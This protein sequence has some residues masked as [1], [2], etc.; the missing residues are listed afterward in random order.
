MFH[1]LMHLACCRYPVAVVQFLAS[2]S[3]ENRKQVTGYTTGTNFE[4]IATRSSG[5]RFIPH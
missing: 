2:A 1:S 5:A 4:A 3:I